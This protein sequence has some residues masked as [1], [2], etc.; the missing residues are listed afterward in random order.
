MVSRGCWGSSSSVISGAFPRVQILQRNAFPLL[1]LPSLSLSVLLLISLL[2]ALLHLSSFPSLALSSSPLSPFFSSSD[3]P[4][5]PTSYSAVFI[6]FNLFPLYSSLFFPFVFSPRHVS[7]AI[8]SSSR[9]T[10]SDRQKNKCQIREA[11]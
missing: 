6:C 1:L 3:F 4:F 9:H 2:A 8:D 11:L 5:L 10:L 7:F